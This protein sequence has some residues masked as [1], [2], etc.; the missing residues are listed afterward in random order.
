[1]S[2]TLEKAQE[3]TLAHAKA[4]GAE[5]VALREALGRVLFEDLIPDKDQPPFPRSPLDGYALSAEDTKGASRANPVA[6]K[7]TGSVFAGDRADISVKPGSAVRVMTGGMLP[8]GVDCV[9]RQEDTDGGEETVL[10]Y[11]R[12]RPFDNY[13]FRGDDFKAGE[14]LIPRGTRL[15]AAAVSVA[16]AAGAFELAVFKRPRV[17]VISTGDELLEPG[18]PLPAGKIYDSNMFY[19]TSRLRETGAHI[20]AELIAPDNFEKIS[21]ALSD[22]AGKTDLI[23]TTGGVSV[24]K[25]D[26]LPAVTSALGA[27]LVFSG[28]SMKPGS[29]TL[30]TCIADTPVLSLSGNPFACSAC[31]ELLARGLLAKLSGNTE[32]QL[33]TA[34]SKLLSD[35]PKK[36]TGR[37]LIRG[38]YTPEGVLLPEGH[39]SGQMRSMMGCNCFV[40]IPAGT[41]KLHAGDPVRVILL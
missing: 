17:A 32:T 11:E 20:T 39:S 10:I 38:K 37:R 36:S 13:C 31:F 26:L 16:A 5:K 29:P 22:L 30:F 7:V 1:M 41:G 28:V 2:V 33:L 27:R 15:D 12:L 9:I 21:S 18:T 6:L 14:L 3:L 35:F 40:D 24:G 23:I 34:E 8:D 19:L 25:K 4:T